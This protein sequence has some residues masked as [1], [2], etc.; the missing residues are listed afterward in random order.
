MERTRTRTHQCL[1]TALVHACSPAKRVSA[2]QALNHPWLATERAEYDRFMAQR[3][4]AQADG[5]ASGPHEGSCLGAA[6]VPCAAIPAPLCSLTAD[7]GD[8]NA[9]QV[10]QP[11][12]RLATGDAAAGAL[13]Q[14]PLGEQPGASKSDPAAVP[15]QLTSGDRPEAPAAGALVSSCT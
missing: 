6:T 8:N 4:A 5:G 10:G 11:V 1:I 3:M 2:A 12:A 7:R 15:T 9:A 14:Q 13:L